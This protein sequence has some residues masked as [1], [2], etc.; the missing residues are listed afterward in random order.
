[1]NP[2]IYDP[3]GD[4]VVQELTAFPAGGDVTFLAQSTQGIPAGA[5]ADF[6]VVMTPRDDAAGAP[7]KNFTARLPSILNYDP[8]NDSS[9]VT[10]GTAPEAI[11]LRLGRTGQT[12]NLSL[13]VA[14][15]I[16]LWRLSHWGDPSDQGAGANNADPDRD[17]IPNLVEYA[18][19][20]FPTT[21]EPNGGAAFKMRPPVRIN[22]AYF[23][24]FAV[25]TRPD[26]R[27][28]VQSSYGLE[29]G[30]WDLTQREGT[31]EWSGP[32]P[33]TPGPVDQGR[34]WFRVRHEVNA[35]QQFYRLKVTEIPVP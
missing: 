2:G 15:P 28:G 32:L 35:P 33:P 16:Q 13:G 6:F 19:N 23:V 17:G 8:A 22:G 18:C 7:V 21:P 29:Y 5:E 9:A 12:A 25:G 14:T 10:Y 1:V 20:S 4:T 11:G 24:E 26:V 27:I 31:G 34:Y 3:A 30:W